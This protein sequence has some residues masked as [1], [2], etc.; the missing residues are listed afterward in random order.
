MVGKQGSRCLEQKAERPH[1]QPLAQSNEESITV[2]AER[3]Q[4]LEQDPDCPQS[5]T[6]ETEGVDW[7]WGQ[8]LL[9]RTS[10]SRAPPPKSSKTSP[11][12]ATIGGLSVQTR[13]L[14]S[15]VGGL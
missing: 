13:A 6:W 9:S 11:N 2:G 3:P 1:L 12:S 15:M 4:V 10:S 7:K 8:S 14:E 5:V